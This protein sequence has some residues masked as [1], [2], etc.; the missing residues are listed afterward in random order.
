VILRQRGVTLVELVISMAVAGVIISGIWGVWATLSKRSA[1][2]MAAR[3][4]LAIAQSLL[5][6]IELQPLPG[7]AVAA[8][9]PGR[10]GYASIMDYNGLSLTGIQDAEGLA[11]PGL[12]GYSAAISVA[13]TALSGIPQ[14]Q[15]WWIE[16][17]VTGPD[18]RSQSLGSWRANR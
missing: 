17:I 12:E 18:G 13:P 4:T 15:G 8:S 6:E 7:T 9:A 3:Q 11:I 5:R 2:P 16:V 10:I 14:N 1:D